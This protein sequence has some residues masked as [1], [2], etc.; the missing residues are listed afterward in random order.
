MVPG[1]EDPEKEAARAEE[2]AKKN[3]EMMKEKHPEHQDFRLDR[4]TVD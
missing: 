1:E 4:L 2:L 3:E